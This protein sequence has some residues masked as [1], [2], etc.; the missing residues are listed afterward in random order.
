MAARP[1][2]VSDPAAR[3]KAARRYRAGPCTKSNLLLRSL[4]RALSKDK[5]GRRISEP[6]AG[7][8]FADDLDEDDQVSGTI[9]VSRGKSDHPLVAANR[10]LTRKIGVTSGGVE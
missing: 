6:T 7:P 2:T 3:R 4:Q 9:Y 10:D 8:L 1:G 5:A